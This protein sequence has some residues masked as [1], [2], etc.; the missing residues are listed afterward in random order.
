MDAKFNFDENA[1][2]RQPDIFQ[3]RDTS[4]ESAA[5]VKASQYDLNYI[6]LDGSIGC[7]GSSGFECFLPLTQ[8]SFQ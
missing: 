4:Q 3:M 7:L 6:E 8:K 2:F 1:K 5:E